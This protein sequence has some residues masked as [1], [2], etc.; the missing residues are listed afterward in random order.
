[1]AVIVASPPAV[2][3]ELAEAPWIAG[4]ANALFD[5]CLYLPLTAFTY[6]VYRRVQAV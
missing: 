1:V 3:A 2:S 6:T 4:L 5:V